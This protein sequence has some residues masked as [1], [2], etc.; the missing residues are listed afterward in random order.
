MMT[1]AAPQ[2]AARP[3]PPPGVSRFAVSQPHNGLFAQSEP[4]PPPAPAP[5]K[6]IFGLVTGAIRGTN[7]ATPDPVAVEPQRVE[8]R[9]D[10]RPDSS[11]VLRAEPALD[12]NRAN[13]RQAGGDEMNIDIPAFLRRQ[14]S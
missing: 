6:S 11:P 14:T 13:V 9:M 5:R 12:R 2:P 8:Q 10:P 7:H 4:T 3:A 1:Q